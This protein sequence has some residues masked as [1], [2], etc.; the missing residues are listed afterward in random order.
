M[1]NTRIDQAIAEEYSLVLDVTVDE[2]L[3]PEAEPSEWDL[4]PDDG[5][6]F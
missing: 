1:I 5:P 4:R 6:A 2:M 3:E